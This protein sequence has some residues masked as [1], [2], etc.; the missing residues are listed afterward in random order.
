MTTVSRIL[1][2]K[3]YQRKTCV[4]IYNLPYQQNSFCSQDIQHFH[5]G[6]RHAQSIPCGSYEHAHSLFWEQHSVQ[7]MQWSINSETEQWILQEPASKNITQIFILYYLSSVY[8]PTSKFSFFSNYINYSSFSYLS[9]SFKLNFS[10][11]FKH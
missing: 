7:N 6:K 9:E 1:K 11:I 8:Y 2:N 4:K 5:C 3:Q 10:A